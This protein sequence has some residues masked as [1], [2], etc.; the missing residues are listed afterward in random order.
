MS[1]AE[2]AYE[3][4][5]R[6]LLDGTVVNKHGIILKPFITRY[7]Y[8][9]ILVTFEKRRKGVS[10]A[11]LQS[12][13]KYGKKAVEPKI[14]ARHLNGNSL[15]NSYDNI[16][17]GTHSENMMDIPKDVRLRIATHAASFLK[18]HNHEAIREYYSQTNSYKSTM[19][20]FGISSKG[21]LHFIL[22][23]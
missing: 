18:K 15:D 22:K 14:E 5:Y 7:G 13:I 21:T 2:I 10:V 11:K 1:N 8:A 17:I 3:K 23:G 12:Y 19:E 9:M 16:G 20:I 6:V 4:G